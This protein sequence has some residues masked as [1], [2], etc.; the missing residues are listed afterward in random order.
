MSEPVK[1]IGKTPE[2]YSPKDK[3][4]I[5]NMMEN[6]NQ[7]TNPDENVL[8]G[9][10]HMGYGSPSAVCY[11]GSVMRLMDYLDD[12]VEADELFSLSGAALCFP[13]KAGLPCDEISALTE[14][15]ERTFA[16]LGY[17]SEYYYEPYIK[18]APRKYTK[19]FYAGK[20]KESIDNNRPVVG[21]GFTELNFTCLVTGYAKNG[22][23]LYLRAYWSPKGTPDGYDTEKYY[24]IEDWYDKCHGLIVV[25][26]KTGGRLT[27]ELAYSYIKENAKIFNE[28][29]TGMSFEHE[30]YNN[31]TAFDD[32]ISWL[33][34]D[35]LWAEADM[36]FMDCLLKPC[37]LLL[38]DHYRS[39]LH[40]YL[41]KLENRYPGLANPGLRPAIEELGS[42][43]TGP[44]VDINNLST[45]SPDITDFSKL[46]ERF[47]REEV[48]KLVERL[49]KSDQ[50]IFDYLLN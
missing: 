17:E 38:L 45:L 35:G 41:G 27:G 25:K 39:Y 34:D 15:P 13:W 32:M 26:N 44:A 48:V 28:K 21:F 20:I 22:E 29:K 33:R 2:G 6:E 11:I 10:P 5:L 42:Y 14:I 7:K 24:Y 12:P 16:A 50:D 31:S 46:K 4:E 9:I 43:I 49:K 37:G 3:P 40:G 1:K 18:A 8:T 23:A 19:E 30:I 36:G 47:A